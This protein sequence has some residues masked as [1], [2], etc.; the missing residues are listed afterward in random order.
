MAAILGQVEAP[1]LVL[2]ATDAGESLYR[3]M[4]FQPVG[5][6]M[7]HQGIARE[8]PLVQLGPGRRIR[9]LGRKDRNALVALDAEARGFA[10]AAVIDGL[11]A[12]GDAVLLDDGDETVGFAFHRRFGRGF[13]IGPVVAEDA[14]SAK[15]LIAHWIG[16]GLRTFLRI[17]VPGEAGLSDWLADLGLAPVE[18]VITMVRGE[19]LPARSDFFAFALANQALG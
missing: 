17:D 8:A 16:S 13:V 1:S 18:P 4:G 7:Q 11:I 19:A 14:L 3:R 2:N 10:R 5:T 9:P 15:A 12:A 6:I